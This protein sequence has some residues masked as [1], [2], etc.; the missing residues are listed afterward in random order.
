MN[1]YGYF[2]VI[3]R[4]YFFKSMRRIIFKDKSYFSDQLDHGL[5]VWSSLNV[6]LQGDVLSL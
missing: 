5:H 6:G 1:N 4:K 2:D 3:G